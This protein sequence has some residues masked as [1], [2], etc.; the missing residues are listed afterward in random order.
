[1]KTVRYI[2]AGV[3]FVAVFSLM[4]GQ[5]PPQESLPAGSAVIADFKG[6][7]AIRSPQGAAV[8][9][10]KDVTLDVESTIETEKGRILLS[11]Q[12]G[13]QVLIKEHSR[14]VL[15]DPA[16]GKHFYLELLLGKIIA[17]VQKRMGETP[18]FRMGTPTAVITVRGTRFLV[19]VNKKQKTFVEVYDGIVE[20]QGFMTGGH[21]VM[22]RPGFSTRV[23]MDRDPEQPSSVGERNEGPGGG[24]EGRD[25]R[26]GIGGRDQEGPSGRTGENSGSQPNSSRSDHEDDH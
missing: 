22:I 23:D 1:M 12:D 3:M 5:N 20:V 19:E 2:V 7:V 15:R 18:S 14:V 16:Q 13:S 24:R 26:E 25:A 21:A 6:E 10:Q 9:A 8:T 4:A 17:K 11:L